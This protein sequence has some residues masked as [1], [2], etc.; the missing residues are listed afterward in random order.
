[1]SDA[2]VPI[3]FD[4]DGVFYQGSQAIEGGAEVA[5]WVQ[6]NKI[7][8][9]F[10]TNTSSKPRG[11]LLSKLAGF[12]INTDESHILTPPIATAHWL[13][14]QPAEQEIA[15]FMPEA[16]QVEFADFKVWQGGDKPVSAVIIGD[17]GEQW[18]FQILNQAFRLLMQQPQPPF[19]AL[20]MTRYWQASDG[21]RLDV[22]PFIVALEH[23]TGIKAQVMGKPARA[24][25]Q[26][27]IDIL[28]STAEKT[29]MI[30]DDIQGDV[31][32]AQNAGLQGVLV[33]TGKYRPDD[34]Q[35]GIQ[36]NALLNSISDLPDWWNQRAN[37]SP[38]KT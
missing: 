35:Q 26:T 20:G 33:K 3:L 10:I 29:I 28:G 13:R 17:L 14:Q 22:A 9:L 16:T 21:L 37:L 31:L 1:M 2:I 38:Y 6:K 12:G 25:Y 34:M 23:A 18:T 19:I 4:L 5:L 36:P 27:A 24:F 15:L 11:A 32:G 30:G 7:P 8:H